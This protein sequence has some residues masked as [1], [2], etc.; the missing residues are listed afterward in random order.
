MTLFI[1]LTIITSLLLLG[2]IHSISTDNSD[3]AGFYFFLLILIVLFGWILIG[4]SAPV[5]VVKSV[6]TFTVLKEPSAI[7]ISENGKIIKTYTDVATYTLL[8]N[9]NKVDMEVI[10]HKNMYGGTINT[11]YE[12]LHFRFRL[13]FVPLLLQ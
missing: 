7:H 4:T 5:N 9:T 2:L 12:H 8:S 11:E 1:I 10:E 13:T 3:D 6:K